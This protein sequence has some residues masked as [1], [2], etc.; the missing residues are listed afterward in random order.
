MKS[1]SLSSSY[2]RYRD[3]ARREIDI[4]GTADG[5]II[6]A[7]IKSGQ[8]LSSDWA[9]SV[10]KM[11]GF[12]PHTDGMKTIYGGSHHETRNKVEFLPWSTF[13]A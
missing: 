13:T 12:P 7:E 2:I 9:K 10:E 6:L 3:G 1:R 11:S 4:L 8:I 5:R